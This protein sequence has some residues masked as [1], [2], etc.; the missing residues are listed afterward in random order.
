MGATR[1]IELHESIED[2]RTSN[3]APFDPKAERP[4]LLVGA[5]GRDPLDALVLEIARVVVRDERLELEILSTDMMIGEVLA[6]ID[7]KSPAAVVVPSLPP[8]GLTPA[9]H[10]CLRLHA[11]APSLPLLAARLGDP[12]AEVEERVGLL[13][14]AGCT[15]VASSLAELKAALQRIARAELGRRP[16]PVSPALAKTNTGN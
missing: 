3:L 9:R 12:A 5:P 4:V 10:L 1:G 14:A 8:A 7:E 13:E 11:R 6:A 16:T 15:E 2:L